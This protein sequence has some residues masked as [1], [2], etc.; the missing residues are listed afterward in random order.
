MFRRF[1]PLAP[2]L[3]LAPLLLLGAC[4]TY[5]GGV[6]SVY[7]PVVQRND[8]VLDVQSDGGDLA[9]GEAARLSGWFKG[10]GLRYGDRVAVDDRA[11]AIARATI[12][13]AVSEYG[14]LLSDEAPATLGEVAPG[15]VR[16]IVTR[17]SASVPGCPDYSRVYQPDLSSSTTSNFGCATNGNLAAMVANPGDL[18]RGVPGAPT[19]DPISNGKA[20]GAFRGA[21]PTG[22]GGT[23][24]SGGGGTTGGGGGGQ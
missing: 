14:L 10:M 16:V 4:G 2:A 15:S 8:Y 3:A 19:I 11:G 13:N 17:M 9:P 23:T 1:T 7:Q 6:D 5:N 22:G 18:V 12:A 20:V 21:R 24:L